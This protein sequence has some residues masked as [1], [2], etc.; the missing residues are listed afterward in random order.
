M[1]KLFCFS[2]RMDNGQLVTFGIIIT[3]PLSYTSADQADI[4][5]TLHYNLLERIP[6]L[7]VIGL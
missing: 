3:V 1:D 4:L 6:R 7:F 2:L 5:I